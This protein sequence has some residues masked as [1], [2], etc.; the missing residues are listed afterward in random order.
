MQTGTQYGAAQYGTFTY[1]GVGVDSNLSLLKVNDCV[2]IQ[3]M[4]EKNIRES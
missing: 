1:E 2:D 3:T 4:H